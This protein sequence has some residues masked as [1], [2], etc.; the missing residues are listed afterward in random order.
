MT[1]IGMCS[2]LLAWSMALASGGCSRSPEPMEEEPLPPVLA[3]PAITQRITEVLRAPDSEGGILALQSEISKLVADRQDLH[4]AEDLVRSSLLA[5]IEA[6]SDIDALF[7]LDRKAAG[8]V[9][10][11]RFA[12]TSGAANV[13][14]LCEE[15]EA[16]TVVYFINGIGN[17]LPEALASLQMLETATSGALAGQGTVDYRLFY[18][19]TGP[20]TGNGSPTEM[21]HSLGFAAF[22][23]RPTQ[24]ERE[25]VQHLAEQRCGEGGAIHDWVEAAAQFL[26]KESS[27]SEEDWLTARFRDVVENDVLS[28]KRVLVV[29][30]S[31]GNLYT[32]SMLRQLVSRRAPAGESL[33]PSIG[34]VSLASPVSFSGE[35]SSFLGAMAVVQVKHD[36]I[37]LL[38]GAPT[39][40]VS[41]EHSEAVDM[42][43]ASA[44]VR[45]AWLA[46]EALLAGPVTFRDLVPLFIKL[47]SAGVHSYLAHGLTKSYLAPSTVGD[48]KNAMSTVKSRL[49]NPREQTGQGFL[50]VALT[51]DRPGDIDLYVDEPRGEVGEPQ[52]ERVYYS[53]R[54]GRDGEL[55]R[56]DIPG[57]GP[58]NYYICEPRAVHS[59]EYRVSVNNY[60]GVLGTQAD[61]RLRAGSKIA[62]FTQVMDEPNQGE[63]LIPVATIRYEAGTFT[64]SPA[65]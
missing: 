22:Y 60:G 54:I 35:L 13:L 9:F 21:C 42:A 8:G 39:W 56:D 64:I 6:P 18:N 41:N 23:G 16:E 14:A 15:T 44:A 19:P 10:S 40:T 3:S 57:T 61:I 45:A 48:V 30:H 4:E 31:Q 55:D 27:L 28:G 65:Q 34:L 62:R 11:T 32:R 37:S 2:V 58:E 33:G 25:R 46:L 47:G 26:A 49:L 43:L 51:W 52:G 38:P 12:R 24:E 1:N 63:Q 20:L 53:N 36:P 59:G 50:Q 17:T 29:A 7:A 5:A